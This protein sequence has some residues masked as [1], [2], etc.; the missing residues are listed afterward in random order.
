MRQRI[1]L[2]ATDVVIG[3][4][5][6]PVVGTVHAAAADAIAGVLA[7]GAGDDGPVY[8]NEGGVVD[9]LG[10]AGARDDALEG[11]HADLGGTIANLSIDDL[12][13]ASA[14][15]SG[16][17]A[18][19]SDAL[20]GAQGTLPQ[21]GQAGIPTN[22]EAL[23]GQVQQDSAAVQNAARG[24]IP[25][26]ED[27]AFNPEAGVPLPRAL[28][29]PAPPSGGGPIALPPAPA[30]GEVAPPPEQPPPET[31]AAPAAPP[32]GPAGPQGP[33]GDQGPAG[34]PGR[35]GQTYVIVF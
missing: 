14:T 6:Q 19:A 35:D 31:P 22:S 29:P 13:T 9:G 12:V 18:Q 26:L 27:E 2:I 16:I 24:P 17:A 11:A 25:M 32:P 4:D 10:N 30:P 20:V 7:D 34:P 1:Q 28:P 5:R 3:A 15:G 21:Q 8:A 33:P 23:V